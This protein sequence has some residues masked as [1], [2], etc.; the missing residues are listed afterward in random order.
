[1]IITTVHFDTEDVESQEINFLILPK[2]GETIYYGSKEDANC[3]SV[4]D[5]VHRVDMN[6][7]NGLENIDIFLRHKNNAEIEKEMKNHS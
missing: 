2:I 6:S 1:M 5:I 4:V 7:K 3:F